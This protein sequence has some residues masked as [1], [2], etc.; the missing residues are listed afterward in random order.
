M[1]FKPQSSQQEV[2]PGK[3]GGK[4]LGGGK[5]ISGSRNCYHKG[6]H[7]GLFL[8]C[9]QNRKKIITGV[10]EKAGNDRSSGRRGKQ[11]LKHIGP[12]RLW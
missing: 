11:R 7:T 4:G 8:V 6:L 12:C 3:E 2:K 10:N 9:S 1:T 5:S